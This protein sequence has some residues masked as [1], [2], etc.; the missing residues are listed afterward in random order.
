MKAWAAVLLLV[1][2]EVRAQSYSGQVV[3][4]GTGAPLA[5]ALVTLGQAVVATDEAGRFRLEGEGPRLHARATG[6]GRTSLA[7]EPYRTEGKR[8]SL[9]PLRAKGL[10]LSAYGIGD[11]KLRNQ[12]LALIATTELNALV[13]DVKGDTGLVPYRSA[14][15]QAAVGAQKLITVRD[16]PALMGRLRGLGI[17]LIARIVTFK[18]DKLARAKPGWAVR[19]GGGYYIDREGLRWV[20]PF[21]REAWAYSLALAEE[22]ARLGF[23]EIQFDYVR[24]PDDRGQTYAEASTA[25]AR[26]VAIV[27]F[28]AEARARLAPYNVFLAA[29]IFGYVCWNLNDTG[30]GQQLE[31]LVPVLDYYSPMLYP[32]GYQYGIP[33]YR[34]PVSH[35]YEIVFLSLKR[36]GE[37]TALPGTRFRP[38]LQAFRDY[39]YDRRVYG[40]TEIAAQ[41]RAAEAFGSAGYMLWNPRN[42]YTAAGLRAEA[43]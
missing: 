37:R 41:I 26:T 10:Y 24:F 19:E 39:A 33:G 15:A 42:A 9:K 31:P 16:L 23:D 25:A 3:D 38:W 11:H 22:A 17:Y 4:E 7:A 8:L 43:D 21:R 29:D 34:D 2:G 12:A 14:A 32:S 27:G 20:D 35:P 28:L 36:A 30:I 40:E 5:G 13:I 6:Y 18:D 1:L